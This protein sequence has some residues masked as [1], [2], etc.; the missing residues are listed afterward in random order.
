MQ[1]KM[2]LLEWLLCPEL[3]VYRT[4]YEFKVKFI[5]MENI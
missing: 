2:L 5:D 3:N 1:D 4:Y